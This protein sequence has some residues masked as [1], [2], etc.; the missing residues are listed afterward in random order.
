M[1]YHSQV[2]SLTLFNKNSILQFDDDVQ[3]VPR[4]HFALFINLLKSQLSCYHCTH[5]FILFRSNT[6]FV[7]RPAKNRAYLHTNFA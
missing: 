4:N 6:P 3:I 1:F 5:V 7:T 2:H